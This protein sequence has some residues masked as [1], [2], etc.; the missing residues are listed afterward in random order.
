M[1][2][3]KWGSSPAA[4]LLKALVENLALK[5]GNEIRV[6]AKGPEEPVV[7]RDLSRQQ[8]V[9]RMRRRAWA[10]PNGD[11]FDRAAANER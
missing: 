3:A 2:F 5:V 6:A 7:A 1:R 10:L 4:H 9:E 8:A 11:S